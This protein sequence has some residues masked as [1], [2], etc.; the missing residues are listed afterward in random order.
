MRRSCAAWPSAASPTAL[1]S[2]PTAEFAYNDEGQ[3]IAQ[4]FMD[5]LLPSSHEVPANQNY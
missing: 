3:L 4:T 1:A 2:H 5:Y